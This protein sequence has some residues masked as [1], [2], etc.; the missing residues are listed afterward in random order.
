MMATNGTDDA[1]IGKK[2]SDGP[3][4]T[5]QPRKLWDHPAPSRTKMTEFMN[6]VNKKY[7]LNLKSYGELHQWSIDNVA[8]FWEEVWNFTGIKSEKSFDTVYIYARHSH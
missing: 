7:S 1:E 6:L 8:N 5:M 2:Q 3:E 4:G